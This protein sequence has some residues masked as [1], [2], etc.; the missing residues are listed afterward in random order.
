[1]YENLKYAPQNFAPEMHFPADRRGFKMP[2]EIRRKA[3][4]PELLGL[5]SISEFC[6]PA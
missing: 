2:A 6:L 5:G 3:F 1:M 4:S